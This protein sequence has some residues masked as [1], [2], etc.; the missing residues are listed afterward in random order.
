MTSAP[1][2]V[3]LA[4]EGERARAVEL[5][6]LTFGHPRSATGWLEAWPRLAALRVEL[7]AELG[8]EAFAAAWERGAGMD[9]ESVAAA[10]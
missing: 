8:P 9:L 7:R 3:I 5:M 4:A 2:P 6:G 1:A 10:W